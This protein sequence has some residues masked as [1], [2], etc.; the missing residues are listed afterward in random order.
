MTE[1]NTPQEAITSFLTSMKNWESHYSEKLFSAA[2]EDRFDDMKAIKLAAKS[3]LEE[4]FNSHCLKDKGDRRR[5]ISV[6]MK[7]STTYDPARDKLEL[8]SKDEKN[9]IFEYQQIVGLESK[10]R[11]ELKND[12]ENIWKINTATFYDETNIKW[13]RWM[14]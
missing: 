9:A 2:E 10:I 5:L 3:A 14:L 6:S 4:I 1:K 8:K 11:F 12:K 13:I 7:E